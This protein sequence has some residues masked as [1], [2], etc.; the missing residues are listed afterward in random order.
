MFKWRP[1]KD[2][3]SLELYWSLPYVGTEF[4]T[5]PL[6]YFVSLFGHEGENSILSYLKKEDLAFSLYSYAGGDCH[7]PC[8]RQ[9]SSFRIGI[10]LTKKGL[11]NVDQ[12]L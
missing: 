8:V 10:K 4:R 2:K 5:K 3:D 9:Y 11:D 12:V 1:I 6:N 7:E